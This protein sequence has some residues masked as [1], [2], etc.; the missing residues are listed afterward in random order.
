MSDNAQ[1]RVLT[2]S[3]VLPCAIAGITFSVAL[4]LVRGGF[5]EADSL[6]LGLT[7]IVLAGGVCGAI[8]LPATTALFLNGVRLP[9]AL[10]GT[11][12]PATIAAVLA[13]AFFSFDPAITALAA[14]LGYS[15]GL[16]WLR[17]RSL[18][19]RPV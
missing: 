2:P 15:T 17:R 10:I 6:A 3:V 4:A 11:V 13:F 16:W 7:T 19:V 5:T 8:L 14:A 18:R 9:R 1:H 12:A